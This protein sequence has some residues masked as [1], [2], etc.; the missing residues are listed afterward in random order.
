MLLP[1]MPDA[2]VGLGVG[3]LL[4]MQVQ[5]IASASDHCTMGPDGRVVHQQAGAT[6]R[7]RFVGR[8]R[9][10]M[11]GGSMLQWLWPTWGPPVSTRRALAAL[12]VSKKEQ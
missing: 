7:E 9:E 3:L 11:G 12:A 10:V 8:L 2:G 6:P 1:P 4:L 5:H